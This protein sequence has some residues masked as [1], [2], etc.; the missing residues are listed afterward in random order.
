MIKIEGTEQLERVAARLTEAGNTVLRRQMLKNI[1]V[2]VE[3]VK[4]A[5][6]HEA[7]TTLPRTGGANKW[8]AS[9]PVSV[10]A[11][12]SLR[13]ANVAVRMRQPNS[14]VAEKKSRAKTAGKTYRGSAQHNLRAINAGALRHPLFGNREHW[15][16]T[17]VRPGFFTRPCEAAAPEVLAACQLTVEETIA[18]AGFTDFF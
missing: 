2:A 1:R 14:A 4:P 15:Y 10:G 7:M 8:V 13:A 5:I 6:V 12:V 3:P 17:N 16:D 11:S 18:A 9:A